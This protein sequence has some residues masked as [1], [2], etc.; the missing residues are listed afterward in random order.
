MCTHWVGHGG[1][2]QNNTIRFTKRVKD[3]PTHMTQMEKWLLS[4]NKLKIR[5]IKKAENKDITGKKGKLWSDKDNL[6]KLRKYGKTRTCTGNN[7]W[8]GKAGS[9]TTKLN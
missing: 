4:L 9:Q 8:T 6:S 1:G 5:R 3:Q 2:S 7:L